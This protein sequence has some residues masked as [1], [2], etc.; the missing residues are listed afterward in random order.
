MLKG[1]VTG[2]WSSFTVVYGVRINLEKYVTGYIARSMANSLLYHHRTRVPSFI[3][4]STCRI[5]SSCGNTD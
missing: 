4:N 5:E 1:V 3:L 2:A